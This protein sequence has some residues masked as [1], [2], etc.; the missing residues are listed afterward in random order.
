MRPT[1]RKKTT[2]V[3]LTALIAAA[4]VSAAFAATDP[5]VNTVAGDGSNGSAGDGGAAT[6]A[7]LNKPADV[8]MLSGGGYLI[9]DTDNHRV[10]EVTAGGTITTVAGTGDGDFDGDGGQADEA[11]LKKPSGVAPLPGGGFLI[12]DTDNGRV[13]EVGND[14]VIDTVASG[15][16]KPQSVAPLPGGGFLVADTDNNQ[17]RHVDALGI[18][19]VVAGT[20][21]EGYSGDDGLAIA[22]ELKKPYDIEPLPGG[23]FLFS[24]HDNDAVRKVDALGVI[25]TVAGGGGSDE[26]DIPAKD[27]E[28]KG[29]AG[30][31]ALSAGGFLV[32]SEHD[33]LIRRVSASGVIKTVAGTGQNGFAD[34]LV[35]PLSAEFDSP[36]GIAAT[37][38]GYDALLA[39]VKNNRI[40]AITFEQAPP[41]GGNGPAGTGTN[42]PAPGESKTV[43]GAPAPKLGKA[44]AV[45]TAKGTVRVKRR[46]SNRWFSLTDADSIPVGS[47]I[48]TRRGRVA[49][50]SALDRN[51]KVQTAHFWGGVFKVGQSRS[52]RGMTDIAVLG[53]RP[54]CAKVA[55]KA[56]ISRKR[57]RRSRGGAK[58][59]AKD[60]RGRFRTRGSNSVA[61]T[62]GTFWLTQERCKGTLTKVYEGAVSVRNRKTGRRVT[63][64]AGKSY[65]ARRK[66]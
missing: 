11:D 60:K 64:R 32:V 14:G 41:G 5:G 59:W 28:L 53:R 15:L 12:A 13:R 23:G 18:S 37:N 50:S 35:D 62:R 46:G 26:D 7:E 29:P 21:A 49:L 55:K 30:V 36:L 22:A 17:I 1:S 34:D 63:V 16:N 43:A 2:F 33:H 27:A 6:D 4:G 38:P 40:R 20:G 54:S 39:D 9:A 52:G 48:D 65:L 19:V 51:G 66:R 25:T 45:A 47:T 61:T 24:D 10:R 56:S 8:A 58:L 44:L 57:K 3:A 31:E 42:A